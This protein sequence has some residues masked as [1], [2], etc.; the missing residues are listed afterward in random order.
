M[1][2]ILYGQAWSESAQKRLLDIAFV[3]ASL[4]ATVPIVAVSAA[5]L[6]LEHGESPLFLQERIG[7]G[8]GTFTVLK[9]RTMPYAGDFNDGSQGADDPRASHIGRILRRM[10]IDEWPQ[11]YNVLCGQMSVVGPRPLIPVDM[12][13]TTKYLTKNQVLAWEDARRV[14]KPGWFSRFG[15]VAHTMEP[16]SPEYFR[17][18]AELDVQYLNEGCL[19]EDFSIIRSHCGIESRA[20]KV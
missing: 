16:Q 1:S 4:P 3:A 2:E 11:L 17:T 15:A 6:R 14:L 13:N 12:V 10:T 18:R 5:S 8:L 7:R 9:L 19:T 20:A